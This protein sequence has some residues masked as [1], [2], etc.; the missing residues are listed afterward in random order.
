MSMCVWIDTS[1][2]QLRAIFQRSFFL[3]KGFPGGSAGKESAFSAG[4][5]GWILGSGN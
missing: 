2:G 5:L 1:Q 3:S 4:D